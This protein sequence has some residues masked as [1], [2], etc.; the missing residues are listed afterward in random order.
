MKTS[1][2]LGISQEFRFIIAIF[3]FSVGGWVWFNFFTQPKDENAFAFKLFR[4]GQNDNYAQPISLLDPKANLAMGSVFNNFSPESYSSL[5]VTSL[6]QSEGIQFVQ[7][8]ISNSEENT[9]DVYVLSSLTSN[10]GNQVSLAEDNADQ[11]VTLVMPPRVAREIEVLKLPFLVTEPPAPEVV[12]EDSISYAARPQ[13]SSINPFAPIVVA[14]APPPPSRSTPPTTQVPTATASRLATSSAP[15]VSTTR[16]VPDATARPIVQLPPEVVPP[17]PRPTAPPSSQASIRHLPQALPQGTLP[18][19]PTL[20][21]RPTRPVVEVVTAG[22][23]TTVTTPAELS[24]VDITKIVRATTPSAEPVNAPP[25]YLALSNE[26]PTVSTTDNNVEV[27]TA[28]VTEGSEQIEI[29]PIGLNTA[30]SRNFDQSVHPTPPQLST[31]V[32]GITALSRY[33][34]DANLSFTGAVLGPV[35]LAV[36]S[37]NEQ[38][39]SVQLGQN[40]PDTDIVLT[41]VN[42]HEVELTQGNESQFLTLDLRR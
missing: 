25:A 2:H 40:L 6:S 29:A 41:S 26:T 37:A 42:N 38:S 34:R 24:K 28:N 14:E 3:I 1:T 17:T 20:L 27:S 31:A 30:L 21:S 39:F 9:S 36:F 16:V 5:D 8:D 33:L 4:V 12:D 23:P 7:A 15:P 18:V 13:R 10:E 11:D 35:S 22:V 32:P 19:A